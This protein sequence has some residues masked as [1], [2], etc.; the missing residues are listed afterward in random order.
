MKSAEA[1]WL[2]QHPDSELQTAILSFMLVRLMTTNWFAGRWT[3]S[4]G[5][6]GSRPSL[7]P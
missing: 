3:S 4:T 6:F 2:Q 5:F 7:A 1:D